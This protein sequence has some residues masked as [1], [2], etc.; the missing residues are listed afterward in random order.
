M[1]ILGAVEQ[2]CRP[3]QHTGTDGLSENRTQLH[4]FEAPIT[5]ETHRKSEMPRHSKDGIL[6]VEGVV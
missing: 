5:I 4:C 6:E 3:L 1:Y 2:I